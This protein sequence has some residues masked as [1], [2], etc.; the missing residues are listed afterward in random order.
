MVDLSIT[1]LITSLKRGA[2]EIRGGLDFTFRNP[3][4]RVRVQASAQAERGRT[5][6][7]DLPTS[8]RALGNQIAFRAV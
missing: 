1:A 2:N 6:C 4:T 3:F 5:S 8:A 7:Y